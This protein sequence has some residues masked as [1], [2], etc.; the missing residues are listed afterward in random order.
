L[1]SRSGISRV[2]PA[3]PMLLLMA[4]VW[5]VSSVPRVETLENGLTVVLLED[6][7]APL[8]AAAVWVHV[9]GKNESEDLAGFS[10]YLEHLIPEGTEKRPP[11]QQELDI[12]R[13]GGRSLI[14]ADYDRTFFFAEAGAAALDTVLGGLS[15]Q[16][17]RATL[18]QKSV[19]RIRPAITRELRAVYAD[20]QEVLFLEQ[21]RAAFPG[22]PYRVPFYGSFASLA[23]LRNT[24]AEPFY[25]N[26]YVSNNMVVV[27]GG[28][29]DTGKAFSKV[30]QLFGGFKP[31]KVLPQPRKFDEGFTGPRQVVKKLALPEASVSIL[32]PAPG[33]RHPD[34]QALNVL[35]R[36]LDENGTARLAKQVVSLKKTAFSTSVR[37]HFWEERGLLAVSARPTSPEAAPE[38]G[39]LLFAALRKTRQEGFAEA[40]VR[41]MARQLRLE[42]AVRRDPVSALVQDL[43]EAALFGDIR[44]GWDLEP[45]LNRVTAADVN[46]VAKTYL[47]GDNSKTLI[48]VPK[49]SKDLPKEDLDRLA[50]AASGLDEG[51]SAAPKPDFSARLYRPEKNSSPAPH[52]ERKPARATT[53]VV[54]PNG[55]ILLLKPDRGRGL[56][57]AS[58]QI[59]AGTAFDPEGK[60]GLAQ[61]VASFLPEGSKTIS[62][63][64]FRDR[65]AALGSTFGVTTSREPAEAGLTVFPADLAAGLTLLAGPVIEPNFSAERIGAIREHLR[66]YGAAMSQSPSGLARELVRE[67][68]YRGHPYA[69]AGSGTDTSLASIGEEDL[70]SFHHRHYRPDDAVLALVGDFDPAEARQLVTA[71]FGRWKSPDDQKAQPD[72]PGGATREAEAG[73]FSRLV[74]A[75]PAALVVGFP[76]VSLKDP[77][78]PL[79]QALATILSARGF[80][81]LVL[82]QQLASSVTAVP[83]GLASGGILYLEAGVTPSEAARVTYELILQI[84]TLGVKEVTQETVADVLKIEEG[85]ALLEKEGVYTLASSLGFYELVGAGFAAYEEAPHRGAGLTPATLKET[86]ARYLDLSRLVRVTVGPL[87]R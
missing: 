55:L 79:L 62:R 6:H 38:A 4:P 7:S 64:E 50:E 23:S 60:E 70:V 83:E 41:R 2:L 5:A 68:L 29:I 66:N 85:R 77:D 27:V 25:K 40:E 17:S 80:L 37:F 86:A 45:D 82:R 49:S 32:F 76:G 52:G 12:F 57:A 20:P 48:I 46:R 26:L 36:L 63:E 21:M 72:L 61:M 43:G 1:G 87:P 33:Y 8:V 44:Y 59:R 14:R 22:Q 35:A 84:R 13:L 42:A 19:E 71:A 30:R 75:F 47:T 16:V 10:H 69:R 34:R 65:A 51:N 58:L 31:S 39:R 74:E 53:R 78:F 24:S 18:D 28:D 67:K 9:G 56:V 81:D 11:R 73:E 15:Q 3:V 54:L